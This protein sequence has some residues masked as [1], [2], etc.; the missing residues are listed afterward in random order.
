[1]IERART[2]LGHRLRVYR[3]N[4]QM[5]SNAKLQVRTVVHLAD[6]GPDTDPV[7]ENSAKENV[8]AAAD[9][10]REAARRAWTEA[11]LPETGSVS[12]NQL[13]DAL[14]ELAGRCVRAAPSGRPD[15]GASTNRLQGHA[16]H[17][18]RRSFSSPAALRC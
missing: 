15:Y 3:L 16:R 18:P 9:G 17:R 6:Q 8:L 12:A 4:E 5:A 7:H 1:M 14:A 13:A 11:K 2:L 10:D